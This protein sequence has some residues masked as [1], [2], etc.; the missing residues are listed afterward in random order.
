MTKTKDETAC[1]LC[2]FKTLEQVVLFP[3]IAAHRLGVLTSCFE[4]AINRFG[5]LNS[6]QPVFPVKTCHDP[7]VL[8]ALARKVRREGGKLDGSWRRESMW[9]RM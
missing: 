9:R 5:F 2:C 1:L 4:T 8:R 3:E 6:Y 7:F